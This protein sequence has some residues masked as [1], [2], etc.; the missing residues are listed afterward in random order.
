MWNKSFKI[1]LEVG[2]LVEYLLPKTIPSTKCFSHRHIHFDVEE[3]YEIKAY[4]NGVE[5]GIQIW[6][7]NVANKESV[8]FY[9]TIQ[10]R[11][12]DIGYYVGELNYVGIS[13]QAYENGFNS[14][15]TVEE[16]AKSIRDYITEY[17]NL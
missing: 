14:F 11:T 3:W 12:D 9:V 1:A 16:C 8:N 17:M 4:Q 10:R 6:I 13:N 5:Q 7:S 2:K 15:E